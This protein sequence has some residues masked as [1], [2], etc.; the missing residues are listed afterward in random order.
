MH[1]RPERNRQR[2]E[3]ENGRTVTGMANYIEIEAFNMVEID[4]FKDGDG[5]G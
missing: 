4:Q 1:L 2:P 3:R 5:D